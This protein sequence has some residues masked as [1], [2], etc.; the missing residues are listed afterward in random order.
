MAET[1]TTLHEIL[2]ENGGT[3]GK[4]GDLLDILDLACGRTAFR[5]ANAP[6]VTAS[7]QDVELYAPVPR[8]RLIQVTARVISTGKSSILLEATGEAHDADYNF[9]KIIRAYATFVCVKKGHEI[10][11]ARYE[12]DRKY[13]G[14]KER[15]V[16]SRK[17][18]GKLYAETSEGG[19]PAYGT[20]EIRYQKQYLPRHKNFSEM[21]FGGD[22]LEGAMKI[23][24][25]TAMQL[26][27]A[28]TGNRS[29][30]R[31]ECIGFKYFNFVKPI[32]P[33]H[34]WGISAKISHVQGSIVYVDL[35]ADIDG[36]STKVSHQA[37]YAVVFVEPDAESAKVLQ[38]NTIPTT[39]NG[40][41]ADVMAT[42]RAKFWSAEK[43]HTLWYT[44]K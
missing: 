4:L 1:T 6:V 24:V 16:G 15:L 28:S 33:L 12:C 30:I 29:N 19:T 23:A 10:P 39:G 32:A 31:G 11:P 5:H 40:T 43:D 42:E 34:L 13:A 38:P 3:A 17:A 26:R 21:V 22:L 44:A 25:Y 35:T 20:G 14:A 2:P 36:D 18:I 37:L 27:P 8:G 7:F 9:E 41:T